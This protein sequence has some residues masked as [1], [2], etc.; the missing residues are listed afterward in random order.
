MI[1]TRFLAFAT[2][3]GML[4]SA[5]SWA[6]QAFTTGPANVRAGPD[7][8]FPVVATL[9]P[10]TAVHV[11]GCVAEYRWCDVDVGPGRGW[12][13]TSLLQ[14]HYGSRVVPLYSYGATIGLPIVTFSLFNY[15]DR[16]YRDRPWYRERSRWESRWGGHDRRWDNNSRWDN[17]RRWDNDRWRDNDQR[18]QGRRD[19]DRRWEGRRD[20]DRQRAQ[21]QQQL[22]QQRQQ[23]QQREQ[24]Q[25]QQREQQIR[26]ERA[27]RPRQP[28]Q[29]R[30]SGDD[31]DPGREHQG[32]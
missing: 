31:R 21:V 24:F 32:Q 17:N 18:W 11:D 14:S 8:D 28:G 22:Q 20:E 26:Q 13:S 16:H 25:Q 5:A 30:V 1:R 15:W 29:S 19:N 9:A 6:Q 12:V 7:I 3:A 23:F 4:L 27:A 10:G 2:A